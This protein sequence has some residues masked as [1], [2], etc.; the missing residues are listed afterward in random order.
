MDATGAVLISGSVTTSSV[1]SL[2]RSLDREWAWDIRYPW[3]SSGRSDSI[4]WIFAASALQAL[5]IHVRR[6]RGAVFGVDTRDITNMTVRQLAALIRLHK[7]SLGQGFEFAVAD[8]LNCDYQP[9]RDAVV[10]SLQSVGVTMTQPR[11]IVMG[12]E[13]ITDRQL[14]ADAAAEALGDRRLRSGNRGRPRVAA[15]AV[16]KLLAESS[17]IRQ[18]RGALA[19][20]DLLIYDESGSDVVTASVKINGH[21]IYR[22]PDDPPRLWITGRRAR[23]IDRLPPQA[24]VAV[25]R[26]HTLTLYEAAHHAITKALE[27]V[28]RARTVAVAPGPQMIARVVWERRDSP[29]ETAIVELQE[30][31]QK[32]ADAYGRPELRP[33]SV[34]TEELAISSL[35]LPSEFQQ[36]RSSETD[37]GL[38]VLTSPMITPSRQFFTRTTAYMPR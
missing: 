29:V 15:T 25:V 17:S 14:F 11:A 28:D 22:V 1:D 37:S 34:A 13:K 36:L 33:P 31:A 24:A 38:A 4:Q 35:V 9:V 21:G 12:L 20:S 6:D 3:R 8:A 5:T 23:L 26:D 7:G 32:L 16:Q 27:D 18:H 30:R 2:S 19:F 10:E